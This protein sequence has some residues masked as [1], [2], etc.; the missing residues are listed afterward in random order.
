MMMMQTATV[1]AQLA[2]STNNGIESANH[3][4]SLWHVVC[5][6]LRRAFAFRR[7]AFEP[8]PALKLV[9]ALGDAVVGDIGLLLCRRLAPHRGGPGR[10]LTIAPARASILQRLQALAHRPVEA[11]SESNPSQT[12][13]TGR[14]H[15]CQPYITRSPLETSK[16]PVNIIVRGVAA[17]LLG[18][19][20]QY[21]QNATYLILTNHTEPNQW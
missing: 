7:L 1:P 14:V 15:P 4:R 17:S 5:C 10:F 19:Y 2:I 12:N 21:P 11:P 3:C 20:R 9:V 18:F 16:R 13:G 6:G 8:L